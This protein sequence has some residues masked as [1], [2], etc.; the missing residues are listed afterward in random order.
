MA[1]K[2]HVNSPVGSSTDDRAFDQSPA[3]ENNL[4]QG[5]INGFDSHDP[6]I[7][8]TQLLA[9][10]SSKPEDESDEQYSSSGMDRTILKIP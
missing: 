3:V 10:V 5:G 8:S 7:V 1:Q 9:R 2:D 6:A 4:T